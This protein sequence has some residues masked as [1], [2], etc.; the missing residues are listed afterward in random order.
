M[1]CVGVTYGHCLAA[2][3]LALTLF[4]IEKDLTCYLRFLEIGDVINK[5]FDA[6]L[7]YGKR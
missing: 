6:V 1:V 7:Q 4:S 3:T 5:Q 2:A